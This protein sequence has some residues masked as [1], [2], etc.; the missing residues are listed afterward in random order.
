M[1]GGSGE[2]DAAAVPGLLPHDHPCPAGPGALHVLCRGQSAS[3]MTH[4]IGRCTA[5]SVSCGARALV[6][7]QAIRT[8]GL[9]R[10]AG[11]GLCCTWL[12]AGLAAS[13]ASA[14]YFGWRLFWY[15]HR[16][17]AE[18]LSHQVAKPFASLLDGDAVACD[19]LSGGCILSMS[20]HLCSRP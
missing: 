16:A 9:P 13:Q 12:Q 6:L 7:H 10:V 1:T 20:L 5:G 17:A 2:A 4:P 15:V 18:P 3:P 8:S 11:S 19:G 14:V